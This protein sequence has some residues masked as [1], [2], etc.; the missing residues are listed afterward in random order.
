[1]H[2]KDV[3]ESLA[4]A[5]RGEETGIAMSQVSIGEGVNADNIAGCIE[6][7]KKWK[8]DG[9]ISIE[10]EASPGN[11]EKSLAWLRK[12]VAK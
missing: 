6:L 5:C 2:I 3:S 1:M 9:V 4:K 10:C 8:W 12:Q 7:L 11:V